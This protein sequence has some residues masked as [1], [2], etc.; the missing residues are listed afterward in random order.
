MISTVINYIVIGLASTATLTKSGD[1]D[2]SV[3]FSLLKLK[4]ELELSFK[5]YIETRIITH[6]KN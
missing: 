2:I 4:R 3:I 5:N 1:N 6:P